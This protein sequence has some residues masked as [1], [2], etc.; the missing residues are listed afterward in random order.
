LGERRLGRKGERTGGNARTYEEKRAKARFDTKVMG[1]V[2]ASPP[3][4]Y[5]FASPMQIDNDEE[6]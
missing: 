5:Y 3:P 6:L 2:F 4:S 1:D